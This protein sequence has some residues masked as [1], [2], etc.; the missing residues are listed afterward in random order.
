MTTALIYDEQFL[1]HRPPGHHPES[2][3][4]L[5]AIMRFL[6]DQGML[7]HPDLVQ[8][9]PRPATDD[10][11]AA[12]HTREYIAAIAAKAALAK[13]N[14]PVALDPDTFLSVYSAEVARLAAGAAI[15]AVDAVMDNRA[16]NAFAVVRPPGHHAESDQAMGFCLFNNVAVA[17]RYAQ[18]HYGVD[19]ILIIDYDVHHGNGTQEIFY[20][21]PTV[22]YFSTHQAPFYPGTGAYD[23]IGIGDAAYTTCNAPVPAQ[24]IFELYDA[25]FREILFPF[26]DRFKPDLIILSAGFDAHWRD[27]IADEYLDVAGYA[28]LTRYV[29]ELAE[30]YCG[31]KLVA[32]LEGGYDVEALSQ[33]VGAALTVF[34]KH[35]TIVDTLGEAPSPAYRWNSVAVT[36]Q[37]RAVQE[38]TG[39]RRKPRIPGP[40]PDSW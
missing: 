7:D 32:V 35:G 38:L 37:L 23:E 5:R 40:A 10:E 18:N 20:A 16:T 22:A 1:E 36:D 19:K 29:Q 12:V 28:M 24:S 34:M 6:R 11:L 26:A 33:C 14:A 21:D 15:T 13:P 17:A 9:T 8:L 27:Q 30:T 3:E 25:I 31:G 39:Y 4:R 2:P